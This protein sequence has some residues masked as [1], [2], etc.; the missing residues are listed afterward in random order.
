MEHFTCRTVADLAVPGLATGRLT[1]LAL[2]GDADTGAALYSALYSPGPAQ[3]VL[4]L[5]GLHRL[6]A[7]AAETLFRFTASAAAHGRRMLL[8][9]CPPEVAAVLARVRP[10]GVAGPE[11]FPTVSEA[12]A[13]VLAWA[14]AGPWQAG[15]HLRPHAPELRPQAVELRHTLLARALGARAQGLLMERYGLRDARVADALLRAV[16][17][18]H[19]VAPVR[20]ATAIAQAPP[21]RPGARWFPGRGPAVQPAV[22][23]VTAPADRPL[24]LSVFLDALRDA[25]C[26]ITHTHMASVQLI[27]PS[28]NTLWLESSCGLPADF[29]HFFAVTDDAGS[30]CGEAARKSERIVVDDVVTAPNFDEPSRAMVLAAHSRSVQSTPIPGPAGRPQGMFSTHHERPGRAFTGAELGAL[31]AVAREAGAWLDWYRTTTLQDALE[32]L[33]RRARAR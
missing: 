15:A 20:L 10:P 16:G 27:D 22:G 18:E 4:D 14:V 28:D 12:L 19:R 26:A 31:D 30:C 24:P 13:A 7:T 5:G 8:V 23:F 33:H 21:P 32:D 1:V 17:R 6:S 25:V 11:Q 9:D 2:Y 3:L 29:V